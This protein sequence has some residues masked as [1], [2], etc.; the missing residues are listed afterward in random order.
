MH[1]TSKFEI[2]VDNPM[3]SQ[4]VDFG[5]LSL[6][7]TP[8]FPGFKLCQNIDF[9]SHSTMRSKLFRIVAVIEL[10]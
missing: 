2:L 5:I 4:T 6:D 8:P 7:L 10:K 1:G 3:L 9:P